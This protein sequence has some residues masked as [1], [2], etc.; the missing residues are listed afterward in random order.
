MKLSKKFKNIIIVLFFIILILLI[1]FFMMLNGYIIPTKLEAEKY[2]IKGVD[3]SEYQG[4]INW[5]KIKDQGIS[6]AFIKAT[7]GKEGKDNYFES[8]FQKLKQMDILLG[9][10]HFFS[11]KSSGE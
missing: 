1:M 7:E 9:C 10:Y 2:E 8:N 4:E 6:F 11:F 3:I 5:D